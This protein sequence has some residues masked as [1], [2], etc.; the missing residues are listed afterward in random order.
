MVKAKFDIPNQ[1]PT[2]VARPLYAGV[3]ATDRVVEVVREAVADV[4]ERARAFQKTVTGLDYQP[5]ALR[6]QATHA[7]TAG[8][9][10]IGK[11]AQ[12]RRH[13][14]EQRVA[15]QVATAESTYDDL[16]K[17]GETLVGRIRRQQ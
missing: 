15:D 3:G 13:A 8:V 1:L 16:V 2:S 6:E 10:V 7:V 17:L 5:Q 4:Q 14:L 11:D 12:A 9:D